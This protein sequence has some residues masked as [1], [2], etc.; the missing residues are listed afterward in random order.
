[1]GQIHKMLSSCS[2][3]GLKFEIHLNS[4][5]KNQ[6][7]FFSP[8]GPPP[9][10]RPTATCGP[11][12]PRARARVTP[13]RPRPSRPPSPST[14]PR[15]RADAAPRRDRGRGAPP[16]GGPAPAA[17]AARQPRPATAPTRPPTPAAARAPARSR[18]HSLLLPSRAESPQ[19]RPRHDRRS[20]GVKRP[21]RRTISQLPAP[22]APPRLPPIQAR[23]CAVFRALGELLHASPPTA[24]APP[25]AAPVEAAPRYP[26]A[27]LF[28][29]N[30]F[31]TSPR[32]AC[33]RC[34]ARSRPETA[35]RPQP[36]PRRRARERRRRALLL[37]G[38]KPCPWAAPRAGRLGGPPARARQAG[39]GHG[40]TVD[41]GPAQFLF[42]KTNF[43]F[44]YY[45]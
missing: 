41:L 16:R 3:F 43:D 29:K 38:A 4:K 18:P 40:P 13:P 15:P 7:F 30:G 14:R 6:K 33:A 2:K 27:P 39:N 42:R 24:M 21:H 22:A 28:S 25:R 1:L 8:R 17:P 10:V 35:G 36:P 34:P 23:V 20:A 5:I 45:S 26:L 32:F 12:H 37:A 11:R 31:A 44:F 19:L 9:P